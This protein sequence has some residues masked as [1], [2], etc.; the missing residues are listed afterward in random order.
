MLKSHALAI[1]RNSVTGYV[2][3]V[4]REEDLSY[5]NIVP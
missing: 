5:S 1:V 2:T 4:S 3:F